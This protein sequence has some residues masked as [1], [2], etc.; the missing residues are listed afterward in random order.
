MVTKVRGQYH[1]IAGN[2]STFGY[3]AQQETGKKWQSLIKSLRKK[4]M[5]YCVVR[6][7]AFKYGKNTKDWKIRSQAL[8]ADLYQ[9]KGAV[10]RLDGD[11]VL[12]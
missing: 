5:P 1:Q 12:V 8:K 4:I 3:Q 11:G 7:M 6:L 10:Q 2:S 9:L